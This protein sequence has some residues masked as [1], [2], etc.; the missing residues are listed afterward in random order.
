LVADIAHIS[1][2]V[3]AGVHQSP[4]PHAD[5]VSSTTHKTFR[6]PRGGMLMCKEEHAAAIDRAVFPGLQGGPHNHTTAG[7]AVAAKEAATDSFRA[8]ARQIV[9][10][11]KALG[12]GLEQEGFRL[13]TGGTDNH[14]LLI[15]LRPLGVLGKPAAQALNRAGI[16]CNYNTVPFDTQKA[17]NPSGIRLGTPAITSR[18]MGVAEMAEI[19]G[20]IGRVVKNID[21][22]A[23]IA[24]TAAEVAER[25]R[26]FPA[27]GLEN[28]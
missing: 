3:A 21:D 26:D 11:A 7:I 22:D 9:D 25:L 27:P 4:I 12:A 14:L 20:W 24:R 1:G 10:N 19:A 15:D 28:V 16:V 18:G 23:L 5:V 8:Y 6:G 2:L 17:F 13:V